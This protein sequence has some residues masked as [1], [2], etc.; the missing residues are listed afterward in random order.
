M[1]H[2]TAVALAALVASAAATPIEQ[3]LAKRGT[4][5]L[6]MVAGP[7]KPPVP[8][9]MRR[10]FA[11]F[12]GTL[13][14]VISA[15]ATSADVGTGSVAAVPEDNDLEYLCEATIGGSTLHLNFDTGSAD[16]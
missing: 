6:K 7:A 10:T 1:P 15:A 3:Q 11:K 12:N 2:Y 13:P 8:V 5:S 9:L 16:L 4:F 14:E